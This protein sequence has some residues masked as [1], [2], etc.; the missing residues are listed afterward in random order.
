MVLVAASLFE[1]CMVHDQVR[2][3]VDGP[4]LLVWVVV[5]AIES[6]CQEARGSALLLVGSGVAVEKSTRWVVERRA[7]EG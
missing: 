7:K 3:E 5:L 6:D 2:R 4:F 1:A